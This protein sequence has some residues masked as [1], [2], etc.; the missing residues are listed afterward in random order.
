M[1]KGNFVDNFFLP[2]Y[3]IVHDVT[4]G[5]VEA[6]PQ[7]HLHFQP[8]NTVRTFHES[9]VHIA[10]VEKAFALAA[11]GEGW[12]FESKGHR[13]TE[14]IGRSALWNLVLATRDEVTSLAREIGDE[15]LHAPIE[16]PYGFR[17]T[18]AQLLIFLRDHTHYHNGKLSTYVRMVGAKPPFYVSLSPDTFEKMF[19]CGL[20]HGGGRRIPVD[21]DDAGE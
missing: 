3:E 8:V 10:S 12:E 18:P 15:S 20:D 16:T 21:R 6:M 9:V 19:F 2:L 1:L 17:A 14:Y 13:P 7:E 4:L 5:L 11:A